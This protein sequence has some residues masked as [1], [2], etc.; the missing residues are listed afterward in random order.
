MKSTKQI[1]KIGIF[2]ALITL[3]ACGRSNRQ[4]DDKQD[5]T[6]NAHEKMSEQDSNKGTDADMHEQ[7][8]SLAENF[9]HTNAV[10]LDQVYQLDETTEQEEALR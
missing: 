4:Q 5:L 7:H 6:S 8:R 1:L 10:L 9:K 3:T 2:S